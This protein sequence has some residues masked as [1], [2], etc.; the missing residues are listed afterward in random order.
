MQVSKFK[1]IQFFN[2]DKRE[3]EREGVEG[4]VERAI[5]ETYSTIY[6]IIILNNFYWKISQNGQTNLPQK[7]INVH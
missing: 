1:Q 7:H 5:T 4:G 3:R 2:V 6:D